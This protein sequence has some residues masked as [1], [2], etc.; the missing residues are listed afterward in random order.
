MPQ[1]RQPMATEPVLQY[2]GHPALVTAPE[3]EQ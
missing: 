1:R 3:C 2:D